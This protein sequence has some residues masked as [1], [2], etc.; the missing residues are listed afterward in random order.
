MSV[1][2]KEYSGVQIRRE[3]NSIVDQIASR[4]LVPKID[5]FARVFEWFASADEEVRHAILIGG[6]AAEGLIRQKTKQDRMAEATAEEAIEEIR[7]MVDRLEI[8]IRG[9]KKPKPKKE[10]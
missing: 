9:R 4:T 1:A 8:E 3:T 5:I 10:G 2:P 6:D 7:T